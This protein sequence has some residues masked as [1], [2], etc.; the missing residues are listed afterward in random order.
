[1]DTYDYLTILALTIVSLVILYQSGILNRFFHFKKFSDFNELKTIITVSFK[2]FRFFFFLGIFL[3]LTR[4][5]FEAYGKVLYFKSLLQNQGPEEIKN[6]AFSQLVTYGFGD[7]FTVFFNSASGIT[8]G[9]NILY[10]NSVLVFLFILVFY[11]FIGFNRNKW[12][13]RN[14]NAV[15]NF[16]NS[17]ITFSNISFI[18]LS[19]FG[20]MYLIKQP[21]S[22]YYLIG[23][24]VFIAGILFLFWVTVAFTFVQMVLIEKIHNKQSLNIFKDIPLIAGHSS[25]LLKYNIILLLVTSVS[26]LHRLFVQIG[27]YINAQPSFFETL[28]SFSFI[29]VIGKYLIFFI[30][31]LAFL[32]PFIIMIEKESLLKTLTRSINFIGKNIL[33]YLSLMLFFTVLYIPVIVF[34][35]FIPFIRLYLLYWSIPVESILYFLQLNFTF[36]V[37]LSFYNFYMTRRNEN[38]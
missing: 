9:F 13:L 21:E 30:M 12:F 24:P 6:Q 27:R 23:I 34:S 36:W 14:G 18:F 32:I 38:S 26:S 28:E 11:I 22:N 31:I 29:E 19:I 33:Q 35:D 2:D 4:A 17:A 7:F 10:N 5:I 8:S 16:Y 15:T 25:V 1:M 3:V 20:I 37:I